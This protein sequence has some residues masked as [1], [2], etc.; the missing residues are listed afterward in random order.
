MTLTDTD[1]PPPASVTI[2]VPVY[3]Q[4]QFLPACLGSLQAQTSTDWQAIIVDDGS[5]TGDAEAAVQAAQQAA[6]NVAQN[7]APHVAPHVAQHVAPHVAQHVAN[8]TRFQLIRHDTNR[9][10]AA[11]RN[12]GIRAAQTPWVL[13]LDADDTL[14][15]D[16]LETLLSLAER[17]PSGHAFFGDIQTFG[18]TNRAMPQT[19]QSPREF[20]TQRLMPGAGFLLRRDFWRSCGGY[21]EHEILK[22]GQEDTDFWITAFEHSV[23]VH[24]AG[25]TTYLYHRHGNNMTSLIHRDYHKVRKFIYQRHR[26]FI[27]SHGMRRRYFANSYWRSAKGRWMRGE[28]RAAMLF[29]LWSLAIGR[30]TMDLERISQLNAWADAPK[31]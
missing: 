5:T 19:S 10:L 1:Y 14:P 12:T 31:P 7:F 17:H 13:C 8:D 16:A 4:A 11:S 29:A 24:D 21:C 27:N 9:G 2:I 15:G 3:N 20:F 26:G 30:E 28:R 23:E 18:V 25:K 22:I 6:Q